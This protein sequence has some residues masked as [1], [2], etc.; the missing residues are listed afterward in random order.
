MSI[1]TNF[2]GLASPEFRCWAMLSPE[3]VTVWPNRIWPTSQLALGVPL[4]ASA[5]RAAAEENLRSP[6]VP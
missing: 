6:S 4:I 3:A 5:I 1:T 2:L